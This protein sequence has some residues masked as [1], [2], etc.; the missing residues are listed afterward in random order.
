VRRQVRGLLPGEI[1]LNEV[2]A[3]LE[4]QHRSKVNTC[5]D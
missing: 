5:L 3:V 4:P 2:V 1:D